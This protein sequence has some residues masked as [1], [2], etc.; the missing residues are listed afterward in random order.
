LDRRT[1]LTG[2]G[3]LLVAAAL[4]RDVEARSRNVP[5]TDADS[6]FMQ[7]AIDQAKEGDYPFGAIIVRDDNVLALGHNSTKSTHDPTAHAQMMAIRSFL[8]GHDP[9]DFKATTIYA[10]GEPCPMCMGAI[11]WCGIKRLVYAASIDELSARTQ[12]IDVGARQIANAAPF[13]NIE[14]SSG[15]LSGNA[16]RLF[17]PDKETK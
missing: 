9:E 5:V 12:Q 2:G 13:A 4:T 14:I 6:H 16:L 1:L 8:S 17:A 3:T 11:I 10:S 7:L 15:L